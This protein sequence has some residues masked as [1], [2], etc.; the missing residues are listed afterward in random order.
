MKEPICTIKFQKKIFV[1]KIFRKILGTGFPKGRTLLLLF[2]RGFGRPYPSGHGPTVFI[3]GKE[4]SPFY[5]VSRLINSKNKCRRPNRLGPCLKAKKILYFQALHKIR[6]QRRRC[7]LFN[8]FARR[9][10]R[11]RQNNFNPLLSVSP[12]RV[13][14]PKYV[15]F[16]KQIFRLG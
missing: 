7:E 10:N 5:I 11:G 8:L 15:G 13:I 2:W 12:L 1:K 6:F 14:F 4:L 16:V 3:W 9:H